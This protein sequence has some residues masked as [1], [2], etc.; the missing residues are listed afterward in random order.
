MPRP[1]YHRNED[2]FRIDVPTV[3]AKIRDLFERANQILT[4][5]ETFIL[6]KQGAITPGNGSNYAS[7]RV[8]LRRPSAPFPDRPYS[9]H[10]AVLAADK[11]GVRGLK[12]INGIYDLTR[13]EAEARL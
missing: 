1:E 6:V 2:P 13:A 4:S 10:V 8:I 11:E 5:D 3:D 7:Q 12:L 9:V